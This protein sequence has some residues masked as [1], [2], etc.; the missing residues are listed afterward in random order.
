VTPVRSF[1]ALPIDDEARSRL[2][3]AIAELETGLSGARFARPETL[4]VTLRFLGDAS[5]AVLEAIAADVGEAAAGCPPCTAPLTGLGTFP[6]KGSPRV[7][8]AALG[9][10]DALR[11]LQGAC[12]QAAVGAGF[13]PESRPFR[14]HLTL[15]RWRVRARRPHLPHFELGAAHLNRLVLFASRLDPGGP[16]HT[17]LATFP[18]RGAA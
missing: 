13:A 1:L 7:L 12:E 15:A 14:A 2:A 4:H 8:F 5:P 11:E 17:P 16:R 9:L 18:F 6:P 10:P 3:A